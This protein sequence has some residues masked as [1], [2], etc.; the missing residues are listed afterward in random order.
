VT[1]SPLTELDQ[2]LVAELAVID[3]LPDYLSREE[4]WTFLRVT[5][6]TLDRMLE[7]GELARRRFGGRTLIPRASLRACVLQQV[8]IPPD[9][10]GSDELGSARWGGSQTSDRK[11]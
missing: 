10:E 5:E 6:R 3:A 2:V 7:R 9:V 8:G 4:V 11:D 1:D